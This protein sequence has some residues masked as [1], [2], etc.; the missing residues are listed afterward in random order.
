MWNWYM[1]WRI[2]RIARKAQHLAEMRYNRVMRAKRAFTG[3]EAELQKIKDKNPEYAENVE[4]CIAS[5][6]A[7]QEKVEL[8]FCR[9]MQEAND[10]L[11]QLQQ[12]LLSLET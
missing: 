12:Q 7:E 5:L 2:H 11:D 9:Q 3:A 4:D 1:R 10:L 8:H 6:R